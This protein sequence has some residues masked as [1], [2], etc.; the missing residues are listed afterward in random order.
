MD[1]KK[2]VEKY[3]KMY[4]YYHDNQQWTLLSDKPPEDAYAGEPEWDDLVLVDGNDYDMAEGYLPH[5]VR[6]LCKA[7]GIRTFSI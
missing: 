2:L 3:P 7:L 6:D 5:L 1:F 4:L